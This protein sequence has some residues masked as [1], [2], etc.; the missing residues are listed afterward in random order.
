LLFWGV[1]LILLGVLPGGLLFLGLRQM[2]RHPQVS[3]EYV[4]LPAKDRVIRVIEP[5]IESRYEY[6]LSGVVVVGDDKPEHTFD[7]YL[8]HD[9]ETLALYEQ[10]KRMPHKKYQYARRVLDWRTYM[11]TG[12][13][14]DFALVFV[15]PHPYEMSVHVKLDYYPHPWFTRGVWGR[16]MLIL[17]MIGLL[18]SLVGVV[19]VIAGFVR[20]LL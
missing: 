7:F 19:L 12:P 9:M 20:W 8:L 18:G 14:L 10:G 5:Q 17:S 1:V 2:R 3:R 6:R 4:A 11:Q 15:N 16:L 13:G